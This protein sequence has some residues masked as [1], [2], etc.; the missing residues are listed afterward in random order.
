M[1]TLVL[2]SKIAGIYALGLVL[3]PVSW[4]AEQKRAIRWAYWD[5]LGS[6]HNEVQKAIA[7]A[8]TCPHCGGR[9]RVCEHHPNRAWP[10]E[11]DCGAGMPCECRGGPKRG[12][13]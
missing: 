9:G 13:S 1:K 10:R 7:R 11:C 12:A 5:T 4:L 8:N 3:F 2:A 6:A